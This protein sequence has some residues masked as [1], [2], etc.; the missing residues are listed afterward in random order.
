M[1]IISVTFEVL[2][3]D[4]GVLYSGDFRCFCM[5]VFDWLFYVYVCV[6]V[7]YL[8]VFKF[9]VVYWLR[10]E[11]WVYFVF[12]W[13]T[14]LFWA[15]VFV[16]FLFCYCWVASL[17]GL[18]LCWDY[19]TFRLCL[20][21]V[22]SFVFCFVIRDMCFACSFAAWN[23][24]LSLVWCFNI[25]CLLV[26]DYCVLFA[27]YE[28]LF[29]CALFGFKIACFALLLFS[30][31]YCCCPLN[32][33][34]FVLLV[35]I[36]GFFVF[37]FWLLF[38]LVYLLCVFSADFCFETWLFGD[39]LLVL[40]FV[41]LYLFFDC[42]WFDVMFVFFSLCYTLLYCWCFTCGFV[43]FGFTCIGVRI[44]SLVIV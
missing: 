38:R 32:V 31:F 22:G 25:G 4:I 24:C 28:C 23:W 41:V 14:L 8:F 27:C 34:C 21:I 19:C 12:E 1:C 15:D 13:L 9:A 43:L 7:V 33:L 17:C 42:V 44:E 37:G 6:F 2:C 18:F 26:F 35:L 16:D 11:F 20:C 39:W 29:G 10:S 3:F 30:M 40:L 5:L 36:K